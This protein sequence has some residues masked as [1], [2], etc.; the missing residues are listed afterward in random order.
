MKGRGLILALLVVALL[1]FFVVKELRS[2]QEEG[3][4]EPQSVVFPWGTYLLS[5]FSAE[6]PAEGVEA[7]FR[8][9]EEGG[10]GLVSGP[11]T[12]DTAFAADVLSSW[13]R[14]RFVEVVDEEPSDEALE[15]YGLATPLAVF[16]GT[17]KPEAVEGD[18]PVPVPSLV[19]GNPA[20]LRPVFYGRVNGFDR[21]VF[22]SVDA[23]DLAMASG[24]KLLGLPTADPEPTH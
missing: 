17:L 10:W 11:E 6:M 1:A 20:P 15:R 7:S 3:K 22:I 4:M 14:I 8:R 19:I 24:R 13:S 16:R 21:V 23:H 5:A 12:C 2:D 18:G 9:K